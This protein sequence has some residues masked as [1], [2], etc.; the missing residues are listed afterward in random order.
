MSSK[1]EIENFIKLISNM[2]STKPKLIDTPNLW[3]R[4]IPAPIRNP[5][6]LSL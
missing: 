2:V 4:V 5:L 6:N 1:E 3:S